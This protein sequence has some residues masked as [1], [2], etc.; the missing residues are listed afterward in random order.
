MSLPKI[1]LINPPQRTES[2]QFLDL[3]VPPIGLLYIAAYLEKEGAHIEILDADLL[4][5]STKQVA[6]EAS[7]RSPDIVGVTATTNLI[8]SS[9]RVMQHI[10]S[11][12][13]NAVTVIGGAHPTFTPQQTLLDCPELDLVVRGEGELTSLELAQVLKGFQWSDHH[14]VNNRFVS[15]NGFEFARRLSQVKGIAYRSPENPGEVVLTP[16]QQMISDLDSIPFPARHL[17]PFDR[18]KFLGKESALGAIITSRGCPFS[19]T[20]CS[21]S[22]IVGKKYR[23]RS[24]ENILQEIE[25]LCDKYR[26]KHLELIDDIFTL[27]QKRAVKFSEMFRARKI[28]AHWIASS[29]VDTISE[30]T[31]KVMMRSGLEMLYFGVESGSQRILNLM[32]KG[33]TLE[34]IQ[35]MFKLT[36]KL[37][38]SSTGSFILGYPGETLGE[39]WETIKFCLKLS[40]DYAQFC[41]LTPYPGTPIYDDLKAKNLLLTDDWDQYTT[42]RPVIKYD[43]FGYTSEDVKRMLRNAYFFFYLRPYYLLKH[44]KLIPSV[45][46]SGLVS[47]AYNAR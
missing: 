46:K 10:R 3:K 1:L 33:I 6:E 18:Y 36:K 12:L 44:R 19:C 16:Q 29:R 31:M 43:D 27:D 23:V 22:R 15:E 13:P 21:S 24:P 32:N 14:D 11:K 26:L 47:H 42:I 39:M 30:E 17:V 40:P 8:R 9:L 5:M 37:G 20:Y 28:D 41:V 34:K 4:N 38:I 45:I 2:G 7:S 35:A 25:I